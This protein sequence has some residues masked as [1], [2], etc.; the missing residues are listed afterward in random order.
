MMHIGL[1]HSVNSYWLFNTQLR[2]LQADWFIW[3]IN[4]K[5][6]LNINMPYCSVITAWW[7]R[8]E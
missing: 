2:V 5:A 1:Q 4:G 7:E 6:T 3:E 8:L